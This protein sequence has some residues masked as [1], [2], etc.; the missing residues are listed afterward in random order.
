MKKLKKIFSMMLVAA[1]LLSVV[2]TAVYAADTIR[3]ENTFRFT[4]WSVQNTDQ[5]A[6]RGNFIEPTDKM[7][8]G[9]SGHSAHFHNDYNNTN[10]AEVTSLRTKDTFP[11]G[12]YTIEYYSTANAKAYSLYQPRQKA[13]LISSSAL[14][15]EATSQDGWYKMSGTIEI[16]SQTDYIDFKTKETDDFYIDN[17]TIKNSA[18]TV[19]FSD[20]FENSSVVAVT[21]HP[22]GKYSYNFALWIP[23][24]DPG[25][26]G[27][28]FIEPSDKMAHGG[29][30]S[31]HMYNPT[32][33][34]GQ[35]YHLVTGAIFNKG[36][37][38]VEYYTNTSDTSEYCIYQWNQNKVL[39][40]RSGMNQVT[41][42]NWTK[43]SATVT[44]DANSRI[45]LRMW[46]GADIYIDDFKITNASGNVVFSD[47][48][49][50]AVSS[51]L[52]NEYDF[53]NM[54]TALGDW[55]AENNSVIEP[56]DKKAY[57]GNIGAHIYVA[58]NCPWAQ[59]MFLILPDRYDANRVLNFEYYAT[60]TNTA[61]AVYAYDQNKPL[62]KND[63]SL[64]KFTTTDVGNGWYKCSGQ[65]TIPSGGSRLSLMF[66]TGDNFYIDNLKLTDTSGNVVFYDDFE[67]S[68]SKKA[69]NKYAFDKM[70]SLVPDW[71]AQRGAFLEPTD[72][73][74]HSGTHSAHFY[75]IG[76][77][78]NTQLHLLAPDTYPA[79]TVLNVEFYT[80][81][82]SRNFLLWSYEGNDGLWD[83]QLNKTDAGN[84]WYKWTA[85]LTVTGQS[86]IG[87][88]FWSADNFYI[89]DFKISDTSGK[90]IFYD[91]FESVTKIRTSVVNFLATPD[92]DNPCGLKASWK[93]PDVG[94]I[95]SYKLYMDG[96]EYN[97][98]PNL[99]AGAFN[100]I[101]IPNLEVGREYTFKLAEKIAG[102]DA[103]EYTTKGTPDAYGVEANIGDWSLE[104]KSQSDFRL[105]QDN[106]SKVMKMYTNFPKANGQFPSFRQTVTLRD[107]TDYDLSF[108]A[109]FE[110]VNW[111][112]LMMQYTHTCADGTTR[113]TSHRVEP[114]SNGYNLK[115][116]DWN[117]YTDPLNVTCSTCGKSFYDA[118]ND[119]S[120]YTVELIFLTD[121]AE[122]CL[123]FD[124]I[125]VR[126]KDPFG[127][128]YGDNVVRNG[129]FELTYSV[130]EPEYYLVSGE[131]ETP[132]T[133]L[134]AGKVNVSA[135]IKNYTM[136][137]FAPCVIFALY[138]GT[139]LKD[140][141]VAKNKSMN[142]T[143]AFIPADEFTAQFDIPAL[144]SGD[145][146]IKIFYWDGMD[147]INPISESDF[148]TE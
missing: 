125:A 61:Y 101:S 115:N 26:M 93:N 25:L 11:A 89:D 114:I 7:F 124:D 108:K 144:D 48:F 53:K 111:F 142:A 98:T 32:E 47:D 78:P 34:Y 21:Q 73:M 148:I 46:Q 65:I 14:T 129:D 66:W 58:P 5:R 18:G 6:G 16:K 75:N 112:T 8:Y 117:T 40:Y 105:A 119:G 17:L 95:E 49:E 41:E 140:S 99:T 57:E 139:T 143:S 44:L 85:R 84:G 123:S 10:N 138:D 62:A 146:K 60:K 2:P 76:E 110:N 56:T 29:N 71:N 126:P 83:Y 77:G 68:L 100:V 50:T 20:D 63:G 52:E 9:E 80:T 88:R 122:G 97:C 113:T 55:Y 72:K 135:R 82:I 81:K 39:T 38:T 104:R 70:V 54:T 132:I 33:G 23:K 24:I 28:C 37:Y 42:G 79:G 15:K 74:A 86:R 35:Q 92:T 30:I 1:M 51:K 45:A 43:M 102:K 133:S 118:K 59:Q 109:K 131:D 90:T 91:D 3:A 136:N 31:M 4:K 127:G 128:T 134:Q 12:I 130:L 120:E 121:S 69:Q 147:T 27:T 106:G 116:I 22:E 36:T 64:G 13:D 67:T 107:D 96:T 94:T 145:Y 141:T 87:L 103:V 137:N 19:V